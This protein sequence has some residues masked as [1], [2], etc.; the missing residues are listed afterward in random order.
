MTRISFAGCM[1][2]IPLR[3][4]AVLLK[5]VPES[6]SWK[7]CQGWLDALTLKFSLGK[8]VHKFTFFKNLSLDHFSYFSWLAH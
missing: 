1:Y 2:H 4:K 5:L 6:R 7:F 3:C 8:I